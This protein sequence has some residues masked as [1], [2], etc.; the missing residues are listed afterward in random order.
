MIVTHS[1]NPG[2]VKLKNLR[3][4]LQPYLVRSRTYVITACDTRIV[5][6]GRVCDAQKHNE[7]ASI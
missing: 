7:K 4:F 2:I 1:L 6:L 3:A 5:G